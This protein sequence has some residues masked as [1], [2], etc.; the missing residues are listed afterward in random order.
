VAAIPEHQGRALTRSYIVI[1]CFVVLALGYEEW[2]TRF[3]QVLGILWLALA[4]WRLGDPNRPHYFSAVPAFI[5]KIAMV[6]ACL[7]VATWPVKLALG[8]DWLSS[9]WQDQQILLYTMAAFTVTTLK[10]RF[11]GF[12]SIGP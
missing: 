9:Y 7:T 8:I 1:L 6:A 10:K 3:A 12:T 4:G 11:N 5:V 2:P